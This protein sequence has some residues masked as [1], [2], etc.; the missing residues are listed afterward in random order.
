MKKLNFDNFLFRASNG[1]FLTVGNI[2]ITK[3]QEEEIDA[4][5]LERDT[6]LNVNGNKVNWTDNKKQKLDKLLDIKENPSIPKTMETELRKIFRSVKY[7][8]HFM[9]TNKYVQKGLS[10]EEESF[11]V[12]QQY[13][14]EIKGIDAILINNKERLN[15]TLFTGESDVSKGFY[16]KYK[17]G[18]DIKTSWSLETFPFKDDKL[19]A[20]YECQDLVYMD[21]IKELQGI[22]LEHFKT[23]YIL[24][25][26]TEDTLYKEKM[27]H[28]YANDVHKSDEN[29]KKYTDICMD[30]EKLHIVDYDRF[31]LLNPNHD[32]VISREEW[33]GNDL[34]IPLID[35]VVEKTVFPNEEK[36]N[37][38]KERAI[39]CR[40][41]LN[42]MI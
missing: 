36:T 29:E 14:K 4:L 37:L 24:V 42:S 10:Q 13:L 5:K 38:M 19:D 7:N 20:N 22:E 40:E 9:F 28:F 34:D 31:V 8:R 12:Y 21:L 16:K 11:S 17:W 3:S 1:Y 27:K 2:G 41:I 30:L 23:S 18:F 32:L 35:R 6:G 33:Y 15:G 25:N 26:S 39:L